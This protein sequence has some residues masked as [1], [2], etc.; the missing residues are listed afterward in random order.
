MT[1]ADQTTQSAHGL[2]GKGANQ[3]NNSDEP[4]A[5]VVEVALPRMKRTIL[6][7]LGAAQAEGD[8]RDL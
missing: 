2:S 8:A 6:A 7:S 1:F 4:H 3:F 5:A